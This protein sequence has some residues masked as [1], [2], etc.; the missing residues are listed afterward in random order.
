MKKYQTKL[1][2]PPPLQEGAEQPPDVDELLGKIDQKYEKAASLTEALSKI[3]ED[4]NST[5]QTLVDALKYAQNLREELKTVVFRAEMSDASKAEWNQFHTNIGNKMK[6]D[7]REQ[8]EKQ[9]DEIDQLMTD[10]LR[11]FEASQSAFERRQEMIFQRHIKNLET[12]KGAWIS[13]KGF[14]LIILAFAI[15]LSLTTWSV[16]HILTN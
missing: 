16:G 7:L 14:W 1:P 8:Y 6:V 12:N 15:L 4:L 3:S 9:C 13:S 2:S 5:A 10:Y 11:R